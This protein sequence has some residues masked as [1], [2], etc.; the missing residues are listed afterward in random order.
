MKQVKSPIKL[1]ELLKS[2][3]CRFP[4]FIT[5]HEDIYFRC[6]CCNEEFI[7]LKKDL[8]FYELVMDSELQKNHFLIN[9]LKT[10]KTRIYLIQ[11]LHHFLGIKPN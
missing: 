2:H 5:N 11:K 3:Q 9:Y 4:H 8:E 7:L 6:T 1:W 10:P